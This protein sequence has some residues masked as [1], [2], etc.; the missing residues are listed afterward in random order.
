MRLRLL[1][2]MVLGLLSLFPMGV[3]AHV[4][5]PAATKE[6]PDLVDTGNVYAPGTEVNLA[7]QFSIGAGGIGCYEDGEANSPWPSGD[8]EIHLSPELAVRTTPSRNNVTIQSDSR[9]ATDWVDF[10]QYS[11]ALSAT[12]P[13]CS[14]W[15]HLN[16]NASRADCAGVPMQVQVHFRGTFALPDIPPPQGDS[17]QV[18]VQWGNRVLAGTIRVDPDIRI[19]PEELQYNESLSIRGRGYNVGL[20]ATVWAKAGMERVSCDDVGQAGWKRVADTSINDQHVISLSL[21][22]TTERF[23]VA[24]TYQICLVDGSGL[25][26]PESFTI[27]V[28]PTLELLNPGAFRI[29]DEVR[30]SVYGSATP[31]S[32]L[33]VGG[34]GLSTSVWNQQGNT[35][36]FIVPPFT[37]GTTTILANFDNGNQIRMNLVITSSTLESIAPV[38]T[39]YGLGHVVTV[40]TSDFAGR[41]V[42]EARLGGVS[43]P[44]IE[45]DEIVDGCMDITPK[46]QNILAT[47]LTTPDGNISPELIRLFFASTGI[48]ELTVT[49]DAGVQASALISIIR[50]QLI[51][52]PPDGELKPGDDITFRARNFPPDQEYYET[53]EVVIKINDKTY[54]KRT[55][56]SGTWEHTYTPVHADAENGLILEIQLDGQ[57]LYQLTNGLNFILP[58]PGVYIEPFEVES[59]T[60]IKITVNGLEPYQVGLYLQIEEGPFIHLSDGS[61]RFHT[62]RSGSF[63]GET[64]FPEF[65][66]WEYDA[67]NIALIQVE[68]HG[69]GQEI[70]LIPGAIANLVMRKPEPTPTPIPDPTQVPDIETPTLGFTP[71]PSPTPLTVILP[72]PTPR[73]PR[74]TIS[75]TENPL[76]RLFRE[77]T[78]ENTPSPIILAT[79]TATQTPTATPIPT[80][81][82]L[83]ILPAPREPEV[84]EK[85]GGSALLPSIGLIILLASLAGV[86]WFA[87]RRR[88][89]RKMST[90]LEDDAQSAVAESAEFSIDEYIDDT[91]V[92]EGFEG[93]QQSGDETPS[94]S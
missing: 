66:P 86:G 92:S 94:N 88:R 5:I 82:P 24:D 32:Q 22:V 13:E 72:T 42:C 89:S 56:S 91:F 16:Q 27:R 52:V 12:I 15:H 55:T 83:P 64:I 69:P 81:T 61:L 73:I 44:F 21:I 57:P 11:N 62:D 79:A 30:L 50:P 51:T 9:Y 31:V 71:G 14:S 54:R 85:S 10:Q 75:P 41:E 93:A 70:D 1:A 40:K 77:Q 35:L 29:G 4:N 76:A 20:S 17:Y 47:L 39:K 59:G 78:A 2:L 60:P 49:D 67:N 87:W 28:L 38:E 8:I 36:T 7:V 37:R 84:P 74:I 33:Y 43:I 34:I 53:P 46:R 58:Q 68:L 25:K 26:P 45:K 18:F 65:E 48:E 19:T 63:T 23:P 80:E 90:A 6:C 3:F